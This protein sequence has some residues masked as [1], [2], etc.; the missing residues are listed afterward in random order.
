[1]TILF[2][3]NMVCDR[4]IRTVE[5]I[6]EELGFEPLAIQLGR[7]ELEK[8]PGA[9]LLEELAGRLDQE[10]FSLIRDRNAQVVNMIKSLILEDV[11]EEEKRKRESEN[12]SEF[13]SRQIGMD[14]SRLSSLFSQ[15]E[16]R[17]IEKYIIFQKIERVKEMLSYGDQTLS[18]IAWQLGYSSVQ[19]LS[20]Q[21]KKT[22]GITPSQFR[23]Q[24]HPGRKGLDEI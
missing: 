5:A 16:G 22:T 9:K 19:H 6:L 23:I 18:E 21:F 13:L 20:K 17:T 14:Y 4:C 24:G 8:P 3:K 2:I 10:G 15:L 12:Y 7:V 11:F 1:M